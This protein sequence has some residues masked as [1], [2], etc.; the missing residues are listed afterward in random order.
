MKEASLNPTITP[1][2]CVRKHSCLQLRVFSP[3]QFPQTKST[4]C[5]CAKGLWLRIQGL[6]GWGHPGCLWRFT[7]WKRLHTLYK[8][9]KAFK[10][11]P[12]RLGSSL[13][14]KSLPQMAKA[15]SCAVYMPAGHVGRHKL[16]FSY[17]IHPVFHRNP[18]LTNSILK[19]LQMVDQH[20]LSKSGNNHDTDLSAAPE[21]SFAVLL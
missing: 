8:W 10:C 15:S 20:D 12:W 1:S 11:Q 17:G 19:P 5:C 9:R 2:P 7:K 21:G 3:S 6:N 16:F 4:A 13:G 14:A 18:W